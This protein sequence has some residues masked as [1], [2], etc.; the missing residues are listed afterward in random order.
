MTPTFPTIGVSGLTGAIQ[1]E[2][3][4][5]WREPPDIKP[6]GTVSSDTAQSLTNEP[7]S[8]LDAL[9]DIASKLGIHT[10]VE[11]NNEPAR[12]PSEFEPATT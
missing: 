7:Y 6:H 2:F 9:V 1:P 11:V 3:T 4:I 5:G 8:I 10:R 12:V